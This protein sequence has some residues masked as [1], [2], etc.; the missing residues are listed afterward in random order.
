MNKK[1]LFLTACL[2]LL[3]PALAHAQTKDIGSI[4]KVSTPKEHFGFNLGDDYCLA[5]YQQLYKYW[6]KLEEQSDRLKVVKIGKTE[7]GREQI[8]GIV[9]APANHKK[10]EQYQKIAKHMARAEG[11]S[12]D[13]AVKLAAEGK[14]VIWIDGGLHASESLCPALGLLQGGGGGE[15]VFGAAVVRDLA[16]GEAPP[17]VDVHRRRPCRSRGSGPRT[18]RP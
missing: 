5:N 3:S 9:T 16:V 15:G 13:E 8:M 4:N 17:V 18:S 7:E 11:V 10:L 2:T 1:C 6:H 14:A 12:S